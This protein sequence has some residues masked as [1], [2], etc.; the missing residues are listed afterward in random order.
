MTTLWIL[1]LIVVSPKDFED[2]LVN[3]IQ[4]FLWNLVSVA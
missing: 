2:F 3:E 4:R 1:E